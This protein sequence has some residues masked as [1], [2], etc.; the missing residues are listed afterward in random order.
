M[1][2]AA[3]LGEALRGRGYLRT[4]WPWLAAGYLL[5]GLLV[6]VPV[7]AAL[8]L[9]GLPWWIALARL[10]GSGPD[11]ASLVLAVLGVVTTVVGVPTLG[12]LAAHAERLRARLVDP[13]P[14]RPPQV[15]GARAA[16]TST[17]A[18]RA[19]AHLLV[20][21]LVGSAV[22]AG[23]FV[24]AL[25]VGVAAA[26]P[27]VVLDG[28]GPIALG[29]WQVDDLRHAV[30]LPPV[31]AAVAVAT[32]YLAGWA[33]LGELR[34]ARTLLGPTPEEVADDLTAVAASRE[35]LVDAFDAERRRIERDLH[36]GAQ[37]RL[38][39]LTMRLGLA[40]AVIGPDAAGHGD[41][42]DAHEMAKDLMQELRDFVHNI[43]PQVLTERGLP[44]ALQ[45]LAESAVVPVVLRVALDRRPRPHVESAVYFAVAEACHNAVRHGRATRIEVDVSV[46]AADLVVVVGDDGRGGADPGG[47]SG[48]TGIADRL[49]GVGGT[50]SVS[51]PVGGPTV[52]HMRAPYA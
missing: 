27:L 42:V 50:L 2:S 21:L 44:A 16:Y 5:A 11:A 47:G 51:S 17:A 43:H 33:A 28:S 12:V 30:L 15:R 37:Q 25:A 34:T 31:G 24:L 35:R 38:L 1:T 4:R 40:R 52:L 6:T 10:P 18:L 19:V 8:A 14:I 22:R 3:G 46:A 49:A 32:A 29:P 9:L 39:T 26:A 23:L 41:L 20:V 36:D 45:Q 13:T 48:I 7:A